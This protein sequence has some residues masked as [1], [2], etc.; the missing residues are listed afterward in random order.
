MSQNSWDR[1]YIQVSWAG[2]SKSGKTDLY[3]V[4]NKQSMEPLGSI[5][6]Y[7]QWRKYCFYPLNNTIYDYSCLDEIGRVLFELNERHKQ[8]LK[9]EK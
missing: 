1:K 4:R 6:W 7:A 3:E 2:G 8:R 5:S 9:E